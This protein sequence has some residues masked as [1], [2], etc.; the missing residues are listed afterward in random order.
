[1]NDMQI[2]TIYVLSRVQG[3]RIVESRN[4]ALSGQGAAA[5]AVAPARPVR[6]L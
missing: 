6:S 4:G 1:M 2:C 3:G 5:A